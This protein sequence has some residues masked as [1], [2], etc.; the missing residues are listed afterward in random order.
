MNL[1]KRIAPIFVLFF[2]FGC[3]DSTE[4]NDN[5]TE[6]N[7]LKSEFAPA[8]YASLL[9]SSASSGE[10]SQQDHALVLQFIKDHAT[11]IPKGHTLQ[12]LLDGAKGLAFMLN[13]GISVEVTKANTTT[14]RKIYGFHLHL[15][16]H[17]QCETGISG[18]R[19]YLEWLS[20]EGE[21]LKNSPVFS[22][23]GKLP[24]EGTLDNVLLQTAYYKPTGNEL[25]SP[26]LNA[27]RDTL[28]LMEKSVG[29]FDSTRF[30]FHL[31]DLQLSN[32]LSPE[33][34]WL[35]PPAEREQLK[36]AE[37]K[38]SPP[39]GL[40]GWPKKN[41]DWMDKLTAGLGE[42]YLE[43]TPILTNKGEGTHGEYLL[44]DRI[45]K[46]E[47]FF[48]T[49]AKV[50]AR[51]INPTGLNGKLVHFEEVDFWKWPM[52]LRIYESDID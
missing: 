36:G 12:S 28:K 8:T 18:L 5:S 1:L 7:L 33:T 27:W 48:K 10:L 26:K 2:L 31:T 4:K 3:G 41:K 46:V 24:P 19:G 6:T 50:P 9:D 29:N 23:S 21:S 14:D 16:A 39:T 37:A 13:E 32:G 20:V 42:H 22:I 43:I 40:Q 11:V 15:A 38:V 30:R 25:N 44:F 35:Q 52:E 34:Y 51:R 45:K 47:H 17:N 49:Q